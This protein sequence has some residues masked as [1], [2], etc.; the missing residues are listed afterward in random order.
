MVG[1]RI[2]Y[3]AVA[4]MTVTGNEVPF[5]IA[6][7]DSRQWTHVLEVEANN[8]TIANSA[9]S[10]TAG[11]RAGWLLVEINSADRDIRTYSAS[12]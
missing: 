8:D 9:E 4:G 1:F 7:P 2:F 6:D 5:L 12:N 3:Q 11:A 10:G